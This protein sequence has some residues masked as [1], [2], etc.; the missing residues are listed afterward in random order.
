M[1]YIISDPVGCMHGFSKGVPRP[2]GDLVDFNFIDQLFSSM[3]GGRGRCI[4]L[5][6]LYRDN[7]ESRKES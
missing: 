6:G 2:G 4:N 3:T 1:V 7:L 5:W